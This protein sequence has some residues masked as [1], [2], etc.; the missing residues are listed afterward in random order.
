MRI[1]IDTNILIDLLVKRD[2]SYPSVVKMFDMALKRKDT[3]VISV[4]SIINAHYVVKK[5]AGV[6]EAELRTVLHNICTTCEIAP[7]T[8]GTTVK[9]LVSAFK[10][11]EDA[12]QYFCALENSC[13]VIV[14]NNE[15]DFKPSTLPVMNITEFLI[16]YQSEQ[17]G[18]NTV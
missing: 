7:L 11:F 3:I 5:I 13:H 9:S 2:P 16:G 18:L 14:T 1:F 10:D 12:T 17:T 4:L 8:V 15:K 6:Q